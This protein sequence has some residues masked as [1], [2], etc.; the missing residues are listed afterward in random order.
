M[1]IIHR[2]TDYALRALARMANQSNGEVFLVREVA[3][4]EK[5]PKAFLYKIFQKL[6]RA[7]IVKSHRGPS[8]GFSLAK[9]PAD[10]TIKEI[11]EAVQGPVAINRC[12]FETK[13]C[14]NMKDCILKDRLGQIQEGLSDFLEDINL[15]RLLS[16][17]SLL[18]EK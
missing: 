15:E 13:V 3:D 18:E 1:E 9:K 8:G 11:I 7:K 5:I 2:D 14:P 4:Y 12:F 17:Q 6:N 10:I 16:K